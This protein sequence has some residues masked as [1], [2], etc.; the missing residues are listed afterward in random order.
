MRPEKLMEGVC[1]QNAKTL[2]DQMMIIVSVV[3]CSKCNIGCVN[4]HI[5]KIFNLTVFSKLFLFFVFILVH[6]A[7]SAVQD[8]DSVQ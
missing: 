7:C 6:I 3:S 4:M 8:R 1:I 2:D 5:M